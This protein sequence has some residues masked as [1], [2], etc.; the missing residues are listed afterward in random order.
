[1]KGCYRQPTQDEEAKEIFYKQLGE[2]SQSLVLFLMGY[3]RFP[4]VCG[5]YNTAERMFLA[6][7][8]R[9]PAREGA[10]LDL[11]VSREGLVSDVMVE[12]SHIGYSDQMTEMTEFLILGEVWSGISRTATFDFQRA[13]FGLLRKLVDIIPWEVVLKGKRVHVGNFKEAG[14]GSPFVLEDKLVGN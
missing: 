13:D 12:E 10:L 6:H 8:V 2:I 11:C 9:E 7:M 14:E 3:F 5:K 4:N 1:M